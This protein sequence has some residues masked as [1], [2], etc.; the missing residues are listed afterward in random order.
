MQQ[1]NGPRAA[2][3]P[4]PGQRHTLSGLEPAQVGPESPSRARQTPQPQRCP[5]QPPPARPLP[6]HAGGWWEGPQRASGACVGGSPPLPSQA[7]WDSGSQ[8]QGGLQEEGYV[9]GRGRC[10]AGPSWTPQGWAFLREQ[11]PYPL[12]LRIYVNLEAGPFLPGLRTGC[13]CPQDFSP[14]WAS[15]GRKGRD[16]PVPCGPWRLLK[17]SSAVSRRGVQVRGGWDRQELGAA[18]KGVTWLPILTMASGQ[19][20]SL[21]RGLQPVTGQGD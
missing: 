7:M 5:H 17:G 6:V 14:G 12:G 4:R 1:V 20:C 21:C 13:P 10:I 15:S 18:P 8:G 9:S 3:R 19:S 16:H 2:T 11:D